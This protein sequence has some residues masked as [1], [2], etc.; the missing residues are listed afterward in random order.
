MRR[1]D[2]KMSFV[3]LGLVAVFLVTIAG[4]CAST[5]P[6][7]TPAG[8]ANVPA[9]IA[10]PTS[11][12]AAQP[13]DVAANVN[14]L[15]M[16]MTNLVAIAQQF[17]KDV[18]GMT[19]DQERAVAIQT[20]NFLSGLT[21]LNTDLQPLLSSGTFTPSDQVNAALNQMSSDAAMMVTIVSNGTPAPLSTPAGTPVLGTGTQ[22]GQ[23]LLQLTNMLDIVVA[24]LQPSQVKQLATPMADLISQEGQLVKALASSLLSLS[25]DQTSALDT[26]ASNM[27]ASAMAMEAA[28]QSMVTPMASPTM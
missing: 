28:L 25:S 22:P 1:L 10:T 11:N 16:T 24:Q 3:G 27:Q 9:L 23:Q 20:A 6:T 5:A 18:Q 8:P 19:T 26:D 21:N 17:Q 2:W 14:T 7:A 4:Q 15:Q 12:P 13:T